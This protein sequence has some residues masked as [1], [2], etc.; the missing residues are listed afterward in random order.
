MSKPEHDI[1]KEDNAV[2]MDEFEEKLGNIIFD[3]TLTPLGV[4]A[5]L[6][7]NSLT[8]YGSVLD[9]ESMRVI[10]DFALDNHPP[11][12]IGGTLKKMTIH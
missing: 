9:E 10:I 5:I 7:K 12:E 11:S 4:A 2:N 3:S 1:I 6:L 8:M